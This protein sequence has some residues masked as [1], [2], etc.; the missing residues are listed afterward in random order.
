MQSSETTEKP[1]ESARETAVDEEGY[2][3]DVA[4]GEVL[5]IVGAPE[6]G[7][8]AEVF[9]VRSREA[10]EWVLKKRIE[11]E[12]EMR[13]IE[14]RRAAINANLDAQLVGPR[15]RLKFLALRFDAELIAQ[16]RAELAAAGGKGKT[17]K[18]DH[19]QISFRATPGR[20]EVTDQAG[21]V[22]FVEAWEPD[23]IVIKKSVD[24]KAVQAAIAEAARATGEDPEVASFYATTGPRESANIKTGVGKETER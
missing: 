5:D 23:R 3:Y 17:A 7:R 16:A 21:A 13:A 4:T 8:P 6:T 19:G 18:Y 11:A 24:V 15:N 22:A 12:A 20:S 10:V 2:V 1:P 9:E 14:S